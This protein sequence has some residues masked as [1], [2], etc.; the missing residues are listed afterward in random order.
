MIRR[1][2]QARR[3]ILRVSGETIKLTIPTRGS[4]RRA[5][6]WA[7]TKADFVEAELAR[8]PF[9]KPFEAGASYPVLGQERR[10]VVGGRGLA[11]VLGGE[12]RAPLRAAQDPGPSFERAIRHAVKQAVLEDLT[13]FWSQLGVAPGRLTI[14][15]MKGRWGSCGPQGQ[16]SINWRLAFA[17][18]EVLR[19]VAAHEAAHRIEANHSARFWQVCER[20]DPDYAELDRWLTEHGRELFAYGRTTRR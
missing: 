13:A 7:Q 5:L 8:A 6:L 18:R 9:P 1:H 15:G 16:T 12:V 17:P 3:F 14:R 10:F 19:Y 4:A 20:L 11:E 2:R